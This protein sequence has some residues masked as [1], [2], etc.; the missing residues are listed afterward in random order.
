MELFN[1][2]GAEIENRWREKNYDEA[3]FPEIAAQALREA[4]LP[5]QVSAWEVIEWTMRQAVL[6]DQKD[7]SGR[8]G[9]P[10]ITLFNAPRFHVDVYFWLEGTTAIHQH[11]FCGAFQVLLGSSLHS[12]YEF[13]RSEAINTFTELGNI[14]LKLCELLGV[15]DV[16]AINAGRQY[17][18]GLFHLEQPSA[19]IVVRTNKSPLFLP[20]FSYYKPFLAIDPFFE[21]ANTTKKMQCVNA[22]IRVKH[23]QTD[24]FIVDWLK[25]VDF[26]TSFTILSNLR[27][28]LRS[29]QLDQLFNLDGPQN[30]LDALME[31]VRAKHGERANV[32]GQVFAHLEKQDEIV[33][34]RSY[35]TDPEQRFF[36]ALLLNVEGRERIFSLIKERF[37]ESEPLD[38][39]LD[40]TFDLSQTRVLGE[41]IPNAL[42][43]NDFDD[44]DLFIL[45][46]LLQDKSTDEI[47]ATLE[48]DYGAANLENLP[49]RIEK[50]R[51]SVIFQPIL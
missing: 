19:T 29:N 11:A 39:V 42:G 13:D 12:W 46:N 20:Q 2:L 17:I 36:L 7:L 4:N 18:H 23:P 38:K 41:N 51:R 25:T 28:Y 1:Q 35:L 40:W 27:S 47:K 5:S 21:D 37:P 43:I 10:P 16:Q 48:T 30:R 8:F 45:E 9:D 33:R 15:G 6:P 32:F 50:I 31:V 44:T 3:I 34:R 14:N 49:E 22:M 26:Q 24:E